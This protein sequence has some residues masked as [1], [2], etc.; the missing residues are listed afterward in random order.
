MKDLSWMNHPAMKHMDQKKLA[1]IT[2][3]VN[4]VEGLPL[5]KSLPAI[6]KANQTLRSQGLSFT[7]E[8]QDLLMDIIT[9]DLNPTQKAQAEMIKTFIHNHKKK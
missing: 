9:K 6:M 1:V 2:E 4:D 5:D 8:E 3:L 7:P